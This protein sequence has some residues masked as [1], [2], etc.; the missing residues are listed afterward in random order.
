[1]KK[2]NHFTLGIEIFDSLLGSSNSKRTT[3]DGLIQDVVEGEFV[4]GEKLI[5]KGSPESRGNIGSLDLIV[6]YFLENKS[7]K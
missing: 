3:T 6:I 4:W 2:K 5:Q 7:E 1:M